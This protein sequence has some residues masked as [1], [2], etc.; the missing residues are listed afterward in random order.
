MR[1]WVSWIAAVHHERVVEIHRDLGEPHR[2]AAAFGND[3]MLHY[4]RGDGTRRWTAT[5]RPM[6]LTRRPA[7]SSTRRSS[8]GTSVS[9]SST[10]A[11]SRLLATSCLAADQT[12][13]A[14]GFIDGAFFDEIQLGRLLL[15]EGDLRGATRVLE[16]VLSEAQGLSLQRYG[17]GGGVHLAAC[18]VRRR[19][20]RRGA[21]DLAEAELAAGTAAPLFAASVELVPRRGSGPAAAR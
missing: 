17:L 6:M 11:S 19:S 3:G 9:C 18:Q 7:T 1:S 10:A 15:G 4:W 16:A 21:V 5:S 14:V 2:A 8:R 13:R 12:H 20:T